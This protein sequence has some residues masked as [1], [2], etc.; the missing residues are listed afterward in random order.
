MITTV[1]TQMDAT[2]HGALPPTPTHSGSIATSKSVVSVY[3]C[4]FVCG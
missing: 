4:L 1:G 3:V 2:D